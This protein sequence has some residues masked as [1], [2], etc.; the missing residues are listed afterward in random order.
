[1]H[2]RMVWGC[3]RWPDPEHLFTQGRNGRKA[4]GLL[5]TKAKAAA[6]QVRLPAGHTLGD[7]R[8]FTATGLHFQQVK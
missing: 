8:E 5:C 6:T 4:K 2:M 1:M 7:S 3:V